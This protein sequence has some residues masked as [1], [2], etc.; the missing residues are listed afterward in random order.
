MGKFSV[1]ATVNGKGT[2]DYEAFT[3][4][5]N[6]T[7]DGKSHYYV[8]KEILVN[9]GKAWAKVNNARTSKDL[10]SEQIDAVNCTG[11]IFHT[12]HSLIFLPV[13]HQKQYHHKDMQQKLNK[14]CHAHWHWQYLIHSHSSAQL[15]P[16][17]IHLVP[18]SS[19]I[20]THQSC[21]YR[22]QQVIQAA[23]W[24]VEPR[25][26]NDLYP[27][28]STNGQ[29]GN[30]DIARRQPAWGRVILSTVLNCALWHARCAVVRQTAVASM[31][32][33]PAH[34]PF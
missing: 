3:K 7:A 9:Y 16:F 11:T 18:H 25:Q 31:V 23:L 4:T 17:A 28:P 34:S 30:A 19:L 1:E 5:W 6:D 29:L 21:G 24:S 33:A 22:L 14:H 27:T 10:I 12:S 2:I 32:A 13:L 8:T 26:S 20:W 15:S